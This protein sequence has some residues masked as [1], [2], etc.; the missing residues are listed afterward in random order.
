[1]PLR[2]AKPVYWAGRGL[3]D[4]IDGTQGQVGDMAML[5]NLIPAPSTRGVYVPRPAAVSSTTF[6]SGFT[7]PAGVTALL[8]VGALAYGFISTSD[9]S[10]KD[11]PFVYNILTQAFVT[12]TGE[13]TGNLPATQSTTGDWTVPTI[14]VVGTRVIFTHPGFSGSNYIG[15]LDM[16]AFTSNTVTGNTH[17]SQTVDTLSTDVLTAGW[18]VG[19]KITDSAGD[20]P[21][22]TYITSIN[23]AGTSVGIS[24][25]ATGSHTGT[26]F[27]VTGGTA[28][29]PVW[30]AGNTSPV[31]L[32]AKP[33]AVYNFNARAYYAVPSAGM[34]YS[35][36]GI[37]LQ[38]TNITQA[39]VPQNGLDITAFGGLPY[40]QSQGGIL[41]A[42]V[43]FQGS[44]QMQIVTGDQATSNLELNALGVGV[45]CQAPNTICQTPQGL[46]FVAPD[47][48]RII[49]F[50]GN[51]GNPIGAYG[52]GVNVPFIN[53]V[54]PSR[55]AAA[56]NQNVLRISCVNGALAS[57]PAQ[58]YWY[59]FSLQIWTGPH[60]F[61]AAF[62]QPFTGETG[63]YAGAG[64]IL[65][66]WGINAALWTSNAVPTLNAVYTENGNQLTWSWATSLLPDNRQLS[67]NAIV[68]SQI[69][70]SMAS[71]DQATVIASD[72]QGN[73]LNTV[74]IQGTSGLGSIW[75][76]FVWGTGTWG[77]ATINFQAT[78]IPW[79]DIVV[80]KQMTVQITGN[81]DGTT[82]I[83]VLGLKYQELGYLL[84]AS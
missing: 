76:S 32:L 57:Q 1:M 61:P 40:T 25:A 38:I 79:T 42:L 78:R 53:A 77:G 17:T 21:A 84:E 46:A 2:N 49:N 37:G 75:G 10:G 73:T 13:A 3:V 48:L 4:I 28:S 72:E 43:C 11:V 54:S 80:F 64:F 7:T 26:T 62:I 8:T 15:W 5:A 70:I 36:S 19:M 30:G 63:A 81:S 69:A 12:I 83:G 55:M 67:M 35:D 44:A 33:V 58:E 24:N 14:A 34:Q 31:Q 74:V 52:K 23:A 41:Q 59:D 22:N 50:F 16:S 68:E 27:T 39:L 56:F 65:A 6:S 51:V 66:A 60:S 9:F 18:Q 82:L 71:S 20:I 45:G 47:G 29:A